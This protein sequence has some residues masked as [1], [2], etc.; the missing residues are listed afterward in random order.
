V[1]SPLCMQAGKFAGPAGFIAGGAIAASDI[2]RN[3]PT[4]ENVTATGSSGL[5][6]GGA[7]AEALGAT[8]LAAGLSTGGVAVGVGTGAVSATVEFEKGVTGLNSYLLQQAIIN[9]SYTQRPPVLSS[10]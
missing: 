2:K 4:I 1:E 8:G 10:Y 3:G 6:F 5:L 9:D 7:I